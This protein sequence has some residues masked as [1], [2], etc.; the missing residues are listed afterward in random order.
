MTCGLATTSSNGLTDEHDY[1]YDYEND[2][3]LQTVGLSKVIR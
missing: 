3:G 1:D 2:Y